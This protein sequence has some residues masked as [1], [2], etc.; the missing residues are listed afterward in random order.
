MLRKY[1]HDWR[2]EQL[3]IP[4]HAITVDLV[5]V[6]SVVRREGDVVHAILESINLPIISRPILR[7]GMALV[8]GGVLNNLPADVLAES[9][10]DSISVGRITQ[11]APAVDIGLDYAL[12]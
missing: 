4:F 5:Q 3:Q 12:R 7:D 9:G 11:S 2:L 1:L 8:D 10:V 6:R